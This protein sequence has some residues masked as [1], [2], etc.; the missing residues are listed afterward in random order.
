[1]YSTPAELFTSDSI[2]ED[3][4]VDYMY[5]ARKA[6]CQWDDCEA[7]LDCASKLETHVRQ[8]HMKSPVSAAISIIGISF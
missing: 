2:E 6:R 3:P 1:M 5:R 4:F 8:I 7:T